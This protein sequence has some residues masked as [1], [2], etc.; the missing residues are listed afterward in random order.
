[1]MT[2]NKTSLLLLVQTAMRVL[3]HSRRLVLFAALLITSLA[4]G[5][6]ASIE[7]NVY[8]SETHAPLP[9][10]VVTIDSA[11]PNA[12]AHQ[13]IVHT[14]DDG[15]FRVESLPLGS[16][17]VNV[18]APG[19]DDQAYGASGPSEPG[20]PVV[21]KDDNQ[22]VADISIPLTSMGTI[23]GRVSYQD[24]AL[25]GTTVYVLR[26]D[27]LNG[28]RILRVVAQAKSDLLGEY[29]VGALPDGKYYVAAVVDGA[30]KNNLSSQFTFSPDSAQ[31][32][33]AVAVSVN[34]QFHT[35]RA[36][37]ALA[38]TSR[39]SLSGK[40]TH[41]PDGVTSVGI[42][43]VPRLAEDLLAPF[44]ILPLNFCK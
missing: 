29:T 40:T 41:S 35:V 24:F 17:F 5:N 39:V 18:S 3:V 31:V 23:A 33:G 19:F 27:L 7:G 13:I 28:S 36:D 6:S 37:V 32:D 20:D 44:L 34:R 1:M 42:E 10:A 25:S 12:A 26:S 15:A 14:G 22:H 9:G 2:S 30:A 16:Y 8:D 4:A 38:P 43:L 11:A 21:I